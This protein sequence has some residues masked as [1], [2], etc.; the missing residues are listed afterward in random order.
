MKGVD[1][2]D[3]F[4]PVEKLFIVRNLLLIAVKKGFSCLSARCEEQRFTQR[5][6]WRCLLKDATRFWIKGWSACMQI[7]NGPFMGSSRPLEI[8]IKILPFSY[9]AF[10]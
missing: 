3:T 10:V 5:F 6:K 9:N 1:Y 8:G 7:K 2:H 4:S